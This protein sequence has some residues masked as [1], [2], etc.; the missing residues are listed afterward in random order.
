MRLEV[1]ILWNRK[2]G[3]GKHYKRVRSINNAHPESGNGKAVVRWEDGYG[4]RK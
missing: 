4:K 2:L 3:R 1:G